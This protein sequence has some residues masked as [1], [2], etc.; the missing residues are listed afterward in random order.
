MKTPP[1]ETV[2]S[3]Y[4]VESPFLRLRRDCLRLPDGTLIDDYYVREGRAFAVIFAM[5]PDRRVVLVR[6]F[7]Y[8]IGRFL[9]ELPS[10]VIEQDEDPSHCASRELA[11]ETVYVG[12][13]ITHLTTLL[14][15]PSNATTTM[16]LHLVRD[17]RPTVSQRC[18]PAEE[19]QVELAT[20]REVRESVR[21]GAID[22]MGQVASIHFALDFLRR[23]ETRSATHR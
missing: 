3:T 10:G 15:D 7:R 9:L 4:I 14:V 18:E 11:E 1:W 17:A 22:G 21:N 5:T 2:R 23:N 16:H 6:Q 8:G 20:L 12:E 13:G 19:I